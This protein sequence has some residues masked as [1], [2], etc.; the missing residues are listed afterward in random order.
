MSRPPGSAREGAQA[1]AA[2]LAKNGGALADVL[3]DVK[4]ENLAGTPGPAQVAA[5]GPRATG[6]EAEYELLLETI[7]EGA[8]LHYGTSRVLAPDDPE[9]S[10][11][12]GD[13]LYAFGLARL[14]GLGDLVAVEELANMISLLAQAQARLEPGLAGMIWQ[15]GAIAVG[16]GADQQIRAA[17]AL[18]A[19][20]DV[21][22]EQALQ[23]AIAAHRAPWDVAGDAVQQ[24]ERGA[25]DHG[26]DKLYG[27]FNGAFNESFN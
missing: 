18:A 3:V 10:L 24:S 7:F 22:A 15:A 25:P 27:A 21:R 8:L 13:Q 16:W 11:L 5:S 1:L 23:D 19:A 4:L 26:R 17:Q 9:L 20:E 2:E 6:H 14:A 12:L